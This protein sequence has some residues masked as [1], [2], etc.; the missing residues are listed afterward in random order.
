ML[1]AWLLLAG[2]GLFFDGIFAH[3]WSAAWYAPSAAEGDRGERELVE[4]TIEHRLSFPNDQRVL[5]RYVQG[6]DFDRLGFPDRY[7]PLDVELSGFVVVPEGGRRIAVRASGSAPLRVDGVR[8]EDSMLVPAGR[9]RLDVHW[10]GSIGGGTHL[11]T[12]FLNESGIETEIEPAEL[13]PSTARWPALRVA[14]ALGMTAYAL[15][16]SALL[17][18][19]LHTFGSRRRR[20]VEVLV[21][22]LLVSLST[23][24]RTYDYDVMPDVREN[25]DERFSMWNGW[26]ILEDGTTRGL[27]LWYGDYAAEGITIERAQ[28]FD[29]LF[30]NVTP[31]FE[32]PPLMHVLAGAAAHAGGAHDFRAAK[33]R[34]V[35]W[36]PIALSALTLVLIVLIGRRLTPGRFETPPLAPYFA[37]LL[38]AA[39][40]W[41]ALQTR[42][43][44]EE[45]LLTPLALLG[46]LFYLRWRDDGRARKNLLLAALFIGLCPLA[47]VTGAAFILAIGILVLRDGTRREFAMFLGLAVFVA[48][49]FVTMGLVID[50]HAFLVSQ[51]LQTGRPVHWN[52]FLRFID[53]PLI[54]H[55]LVG[56]G[57]LMFL[58]LAG[59]PGILARGTRERATLAVPLVVYLAAIALGSGTWTFGW[60]AMPLVPFLCIG[61]GIYLEDLWRKPDLARGAMF[62][63]ILVFYSLNFLIPMEEWKQAPNWGDQRRLITVVLG[64]LLAGFAFAQSF[65]KE[66]ATRLARATIATGLAVVV[67]TGIHFV[68]HYEEITTTHHDFDRDRYFD[69]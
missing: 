44:K 15:G 1:V 51:R 30:H 54:N 43:N 39:I 53:S 26:S 22:V 32:H 2:V 11:R 42:V 6:W 25:D 13:R 46:T 48:L 20:L 35:R 63:F 7:P 24:I 3:G 47:K 29:R 23:G 67:L 56:R 65:G 12:F 10:T 9:H 68:V 69:R 61:A 57:W 38:Y 4:R 40:P 60:Y 31:Y 27:T 36:V 45:A 49:Q 17:L 5:S 37:A 50:I 34:H 28:Y 21:T 16:I 66:W 19:I 14:N 41:L 18:A 8:T 64:A 55:N 58:W 62:V 52:I 59:L 33:L